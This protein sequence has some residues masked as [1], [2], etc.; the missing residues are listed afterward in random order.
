[1]A[2][3]PA[4]AK[5]N[6]VVR[7]G[8]LSMKTAGS[9][10]GKTLVLA[11]PLVVTLPGVTILR[12]NQPVLSGETIQVNMNGTVSTVDG[13][14]ANFSELSATSSSNLF[15]VHKSGEGPLAFALDSKTGAFRGNGT[16]TISSDLKR[17]S[18]VARAFGG[19]VAATPQNGS[20][21]ELR[22]GRLDATIRLAKA[23]KPETSINLDGN[24][25]DLSIT[26]NTTPIKNE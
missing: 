18:D 9:Y 22:S 19:A 10:D 14:S 3:V 11:E 15:T 17:V 2:F 13:I 8:K 6:L 21:G 20:A 16:M 25:T 5:Q 23:D 4:L 1:G 24:V 26:T 7:D 12:N